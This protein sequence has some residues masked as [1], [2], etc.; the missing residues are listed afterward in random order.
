MVGL[1]CIFRD[2]GKCISLVLPLAFPYLSNVPPSCGFYLPLFDKISETIVG[3]YH[4]PEGVN[5]VQT[6]TKRHH[7]EHSCD[8]GE[9]LEK[10]M[11]KMEYE[12]LWGIHDTIGRS[13]G[14]T[15]MKK[16]A[17]L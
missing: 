2:T 4:L 16:M 1:W 6:A 7:R 17:I 10:Y 5:N 3:I 9:P 13:C 15:D 8:S 12:G 11:D 14:S